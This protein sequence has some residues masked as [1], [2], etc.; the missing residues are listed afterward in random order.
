MVA[1]PE[2]GPP[3]ECGM[4][5]D[6]KRTPV[7]HYER[8]NSLIHCEAAN[9]QDYTLC[10]FSLDGDQGEITEAVHAKINCPTCIAI[11]TFCRGISFKSWVIDHRYRHARKVQP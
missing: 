1:A 9:G 3:V 4:E 10:G 7:M 6:M 2:V 11:I 5:N 8:E